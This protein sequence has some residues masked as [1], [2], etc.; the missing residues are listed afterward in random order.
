MVSRRRR[1]GSEGERAPAQEGCLSVL[2]ESEY[3]TAHGLTWN[4]M[5][6]PSL[7]AAVL[8][9]QRQILKDSLERFELSCE[10]CIVRWCGW[11]YSSAPKAMPTELEAFSSLLN[12]TAT[13]VQIDTVP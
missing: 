8:R 3:S 5:T 12:F 1:K 10:R 2:S 11:V 9:W 13:N 7:L 4:V 6:T